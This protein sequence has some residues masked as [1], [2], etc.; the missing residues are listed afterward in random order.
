MQPD[1]ET[2]QPE[3]ERASADAQPEKSRLA[4]WRKRVFAL[5]LIA[6]VLILVL[7]GT[8]E[9]TSQPRFC[10]SCHNMEKYYNS[11]KTSSHKTVPCVECHIPPGIRGE[12]RKKFEALSMVTS[13]FTG[14]YGT[15][16]WTEIDDASCLRCHERRLLAG[17]EVFHNV[18]FNHTPHLT[19]TRRGMK[20][21]CTSC[22][23][24]IVQGAHIAVTEST[25][26]LCHF[27]GQKFNDATGRCTLCHQIPDKVI[28]KANL[29]FDHSD[30]KR[31]NMQCVSCHSQVI[32]GEGDVPKQRCVS[33]HSET[34]RLQRYGDEEFLHEKHVS[35]HKIECLNCHNE[36][37]HK[38]A[39]PFETMSTSCSTCHRD[40][41]S[42]ARDL[43]AGIGGKGVAPEPSTMYQAG[44]RCEA[45]HMLPPIGGQMKA[46]GASEASC[47]SCH[48]PRYNDILGR[49]KTL[50][51][52]TLAGV[53]A[54]F[55][56]TRTQL[57]LPTHDA[58]PLADAWNNID[59]VERGHGAHNVEYS[60]ALLDASHNMINQ[61]REQRG[62]AALSPTWPVAPYQSTCFRCHRGI[63]TQQGRFAGKEFIHKPHVIDAGFECATCHRP[64][65]EKPKG[66]V[67][68]FGAEGCANCHHAREQ[69]QPQACLRCHSDVLG[70]KVKFQTK[71]FDH[72]FHFKDLSQKCADCHLWGGGIKRSPNMNTCATCHPDGFK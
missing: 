4:R 70:R 56:R 42:A 43:Y 14:T 48:G 3:T 57:A 18:L 23:S 71:E 17:R 63:E 12:F 62:L 15:N 41:H 34:E 26:F 25:C 55:D 52:G 31:F 60:L 58:G 65:E 61:A 29:S 45:C 19:E 49:W 54:E 8:V 1:S 13:Y 6:G 66:E 32:R 69:Q 67:V 20:L 59:L 9:V 39:A 30:V 28:T 16:P 2:Q 11:W 24:Q 64:H 22:H 53:K 35:D 37:Q 5:S 7:L 33:C 72:S 21:R 44:I 47:M 27:K 68:R 10:G 36:I 46:M 38:T 51:S 50:V 40:G